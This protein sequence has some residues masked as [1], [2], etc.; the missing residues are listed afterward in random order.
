MLCPAALACGAQ[1]GADIHD[2]NVSV[3]RLGLT[4]QRFGQKIQFPE[5][6]GLA[7]TL[8][9]G[10]EGPE[11]GILVGGQ[12]SPTQYANDA[13]M[14]RQFTKLVGDVFGKM[15]IAIGHG[16]SPVKE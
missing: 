9:P 3:A 13:A 5:V 16:A 12:M 15:D 7:Q 8:D 10:K 11:V 6:H 4:V 1:P 14:S 2:F